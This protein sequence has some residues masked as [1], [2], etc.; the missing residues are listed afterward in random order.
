MFVRWLTEH[1]KELM[2]AVV[3]QSGF[4]EK[5]T[6]ACRRDVSNEQEVVKG[7]KV[8]L[9]MIISCVSPCSS[10]TVKH[11]LLKCEDCSAFLCNLGYRIKSRWDTICWLC[12]QSD[13][14]ISI[15]FT[16]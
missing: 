5:S 1:T 15:D 10:K 6:V 11:L 13:L 4:L 2:K 9:L 7:N 8:A 16:I 14:K 3:Y 12:K